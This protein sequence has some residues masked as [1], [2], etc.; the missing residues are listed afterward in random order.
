MSMSTYLTDALLNHVFRNTALTSPTTVYAALLTAVTDAEAGSVTEASYTGYARVAVTYAAPAAGDVGGRKITTSGAT[1][2]GQK[3]DAGTQT[4]IA[5]AIY[6]AITAGNLLEV[7][8]LDGDQPLVC[9]VNDTTADTFE[10]GAHGF[11]NDDRCRLEKVPGVPDL[12]A[13]ASEN[14]TYWVVNQT[15]ND[16]QLSLTQGGAAIAITAVGEA[17][18]IPLTPK[19]ITQNDTPSFAAGALTVEWD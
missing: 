7:I 6:D 16:F 5:V 15:A 9:V 18:V 17:L 13:G 8:Y 4:V 2:F 12:P 11:A 19:D 14:T 10:H 3:T 1:T